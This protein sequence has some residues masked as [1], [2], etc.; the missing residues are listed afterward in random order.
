MAQVVHG[1][2][3]QN[4]QLGSRGQRSRSREAEVRFGSLAEASFLTPLGRA[5]FL[6][7]SYLCLVLF[8]L[9]QIQS[10][11]VIAYCNVGFVFFD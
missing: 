11:G 9:K 2:R 3:A 10:S 7:F 1:A 6:V 5:A 4:G 8:G